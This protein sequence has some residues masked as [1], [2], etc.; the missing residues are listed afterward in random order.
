MN[1]LPVM[2]SSARGSGQR[3][4]D[5]RP[6]SGRAWLRRNLATVLTVMATAFV[7]GG[8]VR[9][10]TDRHVARVVSFQEP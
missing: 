7:L 2:P 6:A 1:A 5:A 8:L 10:A 9:L 3:Q 4:H